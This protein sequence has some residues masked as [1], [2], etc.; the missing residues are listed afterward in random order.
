M[1]TVIPP[2]GKVGEKYGFSQGQ[3]SGTANGVDTKGDKDMFL[4]L[5]VAQMKYQ[6]PTKPTDA[7]QFLAQTAQFTLVEKMDALEKSQEALVTSNQ[8]QSAT[9][10]VGNTVSWNVP[11]KKESDPVTVMSGV[12]DGVSIKA[13]VPTLLIGTTEIALSAVIKVTKPAPL[14]VPV[15]PTPV[16]VVPPT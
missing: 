10:L 9:A 15:V 14:P 2:I 8:I 11:G 4:K 1:A 13:G 12:V 6:D 7:S 16:P 3:S 5:L